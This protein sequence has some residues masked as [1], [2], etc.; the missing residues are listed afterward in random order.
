LVKSFGRTFSLNA[1]NKKANQDLDSALHPFWRPRGFWDEFS[2]SDH[3]EGDW[4]GDTTRDV[5]VNNS[6]GLPQTRTIIDGPL[7]L[8]R[9]I[10][11]GSRRRRQNAGVSKQTSYG[12]L[13]RLRVGKKIHKVPGLGLRF[14]VLGFRDIQ[15]RMLSVRH[16]KEDEKRDKRREE[17]R[18]S[19]GPNVISQGDSRYISPRLNQAQA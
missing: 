11:D 5:V 17:L 12:S 8:V 16:R 10:S 13:S 18:R 19:I 7:S 4:Y 15:R 9:K 14:Q 6:L 3:E 2:D 1:K